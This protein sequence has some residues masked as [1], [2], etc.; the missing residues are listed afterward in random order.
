MGTRTDSGS[1]K[2]PGGTVLQTFSGL[3]PVVHDTAWVHEGAWVIGDVQLDA[4]VSV[5]PT[6][7][8]RGDMG[9]IRIGENTNIQDGAVV[10]MTTSISDAVVGKRITVGHKAILHGCI[11][12]DDC[13]IGMGSIL[14]DNC[15]IGA[16]SVVAAGTLIPAN[17][18][19]P[20]GSLVMGSP[21]RVVKPVGPGHLKMIEFSWRTYAEKAAAWLDRDRV[22]PEGGV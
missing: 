7:V 9:Q 3:V 14:L 16:G 22:G 15:R 11:V 6:A 1:S 20:P 13:L 12:E 21:G 19:I 18:Q 5:W 4:H 2:V 10:H 8:L 17:V